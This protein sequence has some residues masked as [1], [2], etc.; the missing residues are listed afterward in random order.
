MKE[1]G[2]LGGSI[3]VLVDVFP[4]MPKGE[5]VGNISIDGKG[6]Q[7]SSTINLIKEKE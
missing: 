5:T 4:S 6:S 3:G 2:I 1:G 7:R